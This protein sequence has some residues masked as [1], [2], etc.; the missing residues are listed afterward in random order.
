MK[1]ELRCGNVCYRLQEPKLK[2]KIKNCSKQRKILPMD[3]K[4]VKIG[5]ERTM[6]YRY[7]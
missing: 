2:M 5:D 3:W 1:R 7:R 4:D 6:D